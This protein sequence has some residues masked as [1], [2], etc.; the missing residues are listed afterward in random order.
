MFATVGKALA[1][2][3]ELGGLSVV[4]RMEVILLALLAEG[5]DYHQELNY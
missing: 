4:C 2:R 1:S 3:D 5:G